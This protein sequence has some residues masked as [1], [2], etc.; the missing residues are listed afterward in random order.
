MPHK[1]ASSPRTVPTSPQRPIAMRKI[2]QSIST[3]T[4]TMQVKTK[5]SVELGHR[6]Q[7]TAPLVNI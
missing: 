5:Q 4:R 7:L 1:E 2:E 3:A 6:K